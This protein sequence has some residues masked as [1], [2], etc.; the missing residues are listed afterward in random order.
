[1][2][3]R[4]FQTIMLLALLSACGTA[5]AI[6]SPVPT[7]SSISPATTS[8]TQPPTES[9]TRF[10]T[11]TISS[12]VPELPLTPKGTFTLEP[13]ITATLPPIPTPSFLPTLVAT[14][15]PQPANG[16]AAIQIY[17]PGP[18]SKLVSPVKLYGYAVPGFGSK[19]T[20]SLYGEDGRILDSELLQLNT[21]NKWAYYY[22]T[23]PFE[24]QGA[25]ELGRL[26]LSTQ[27]EYGRFTATYSVHLILL[28]EGYSIANPPGD[29]KERCVI[30]QPVAGFRVAGGTMMVTG[31]MR[32]FNSLPLMIELIDRAGNVL[33]AQPV[34]IT[35]APNDSY[36]PFQ[37][38][39]L[40]SIS[41]GTWARLTVDQPDDRI[42]GTMYLYSQ[43][44][45]LN[46]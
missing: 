8:P 14:S 43:E 25:G 36:V 2:Q 46:P 44:V 38:T 31:E 7:L 29:F 5:T 30:Q 17:T 24:V 11:I 9:A 27:D 1:M 22:W 10:P 19:G 35:P 16:S 40:Y 4:I 26:S 3:P 42:P 18:L 13:T 15:I 37:I 41:T 34:V 12:P 20:A 39:L 23:L 6:S 28:P 33:S 45:F 32:P 21:A